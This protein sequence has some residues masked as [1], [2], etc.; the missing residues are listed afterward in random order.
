MKKC[1]FIINILLLLC[2]IVFGKYHP[3]IEWLVIKDKKFQVVFP[4]GYEKE[5]RYTLIKSRQFYRKLQSLWGMEVKGKIKILL[6]DVYDESNGSATF[7]PFNRIEIYLFN[8]MPD[9][10][11]GSYRVWIDL[12][13]SHEMTHIFNMN[14]G[15]GFTYFMRKIMGSNPIFYPMIYAPVW[16]I[17]GLAVYAESRLTTGGRLNTTDYKVMLSC[18]TSGHNLPSTGHLYGE[19]TDWPGPI[20]KYI[21]GAAFIQFLAENYG[22]DKVTKFVKHYARC[23]IPLIITSDL[24][25]FSL[26]VSRRFQNI[27][28]KNLYTLWNEFIDNIHLKQEPP[29]GKIKVLTTSGIYK[30]FP[31]A[32]D[33]ARIY[34]VNSNYREFP[35]IYEMDLKL[36]KSRRLIKKSGITGLFYDKK[37]KKL[38]F[39]ATDYYKSYYIYS[40]I[41]EM[42][43]KTRR[44][45]QL[46]RGCRLFHP[47]IKGDLVYCIKRE[48]SSS[49]LAFLNLKGEKEKIISSRFSAMAYPAISPDGNRIAVSI[50]RK[51]KNWRIG[52]FTSEGKLIKDL[53][54]GTVKSYYPV[55]KNSNELY[56]IL[57]NEDNY[58]LACFNL[59]T[60]ITTVYNDPQIPAVRHFSILLNNQDA[61]VSFF[62]A[63]GFNLGR[64]NLSDL[65]SEKISPDEIKDHRQKACQSPT[66]D[67]QSVKTEKYRFLRDLFPRYFSLSYR[68]AGNDVQPGIYLSGND[69]LSKHSFEFESYYGIKTHTFNWKFSYTFDGFYPTLVFNYNDYTD[70]HQTADNVDYTLR[71]REIEFITF[72]PL[73]FKSKYRT[74]LYSN[75]YFEK[76]TD[77]LGDNEGNHSLNLNGI[78]LGILFNSSKRYYDSISRSDG[79]RLS[80]SYSRDLKFLGSDHEINTAA[81]EYKHYLSIFRPNVLA[82]RFTISDS[83]GKAKRLFYMGGNQPYISHGVAGDNLFKLMR[84]YSEG[85]FSGTGG[86]LLNLEYRIA[87]FKIEKAFLLSRS[88]ERFY[89]NLFAD[90]GNLWGKEKKVNPSASLGLEFNLAALLGDLRYVFSAGI[91]IGQNPYHKPV[92]YFRIGNSF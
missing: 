57:E 23:P 91:A 63:N 31:V 28:G 36:G 22:E 83:W 62:D 81:L 86:Y 13:L 17:E 68:S 80:L 55:W 85:Y 67:L 2:A 82:I 47:V 50:K 37:G 5:A 29:V 33:N 66:D 84:G 48:R 27:F 11:M 52:L 39:S 53:K 87:L 12:V 49:Y 72:Y 25:S 74:W 41:Y 19:P 38:Y 3:E 77:D 45:N 78:K 56:F 54:A 44:V 30:K 26:T 18:I 34:Y 43:I 89:L 9:T 64:I 65:E 21:Y 16:A 40:D 90:I 20:A 35:G 69:I 32:G 1:F 7:F 76:V 8:P 71:Q 58:R 61:V 60:G 59:K 79:F 73:I 51:N 70:L 6:T 75:V 4:R 15:S 14:S 88:L 42:D 10:P 46:T 92:F 24:N